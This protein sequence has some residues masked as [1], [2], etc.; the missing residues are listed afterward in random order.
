VLAVEHL[1]GGTYYDVWN[2]RPLEPVFENGK[3]YLSLELDPQ[4][5]G[6]LAWSLPK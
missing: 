1:K 4:G 5:I 6:C 3:A 2:G